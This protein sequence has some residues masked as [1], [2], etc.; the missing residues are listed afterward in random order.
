MLHERRQRKRLAM[1]LRPLR[2]SLQQLLQLLLQLPFLPARRV[3]AHGSG[4]R[5]PDVFIVAAHQL[6]EETD[7]VGHDR[8]R[9]RRAG[10]AQHNLERLD[11]AELDASLVGLGA[12]QQVVEQGVDAGAHAD[13]EGEGADGA[14]ADNLV[15]LG[16]GL[17]EGG[18][19]LGEEGLHHDAALDEEEGEGP[20]DRALDLPGEAV[21]DDADQR[22]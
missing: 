18:L 16:E 10:S 17:D 7:D 14:T 20:E 3:R 4:R 11:E 9:G 8:S 12:S 22:A 6:E 13:E 21:P 15:G 19:Q 5:R 1:S 2:I